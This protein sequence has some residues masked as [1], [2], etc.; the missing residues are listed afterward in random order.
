MTVMSERP[1]LD[2]NDERGLLL[3]F[4]PWLRL[5]AMRFPQMMPSRNE[6]LAQEGWIAIWR[7]I[8]TLKE[9]SIDKRPDDI[10]LWLKR[11]AT[12]RMANVVNSWKAQSRDVY[13]TTFVDF[14]AEWDDGATWAAHLALTT[15]LG[16]VEIAYHYGEI[17]KAVNRLPRSQRQYVIRK[18]WY[19]W[20]PTSLDLY[21]TNSRKTWKDAK[22]TL[23]SELVHLADMC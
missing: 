9:K 7:G 21:F 23:A 13:N 5:V 6:D 12:N 15:D 14:N 22:D 8:Q 18:F 11:C 4:R 1:V 19:R 2:L 20:A 3:Y 17:L 10:E 16:D